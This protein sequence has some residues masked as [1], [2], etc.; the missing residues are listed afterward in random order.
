MELEAA[1]NDPLG[2]VKPDQESFDF[3][4]EVGW[5]RKKR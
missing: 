2:V 5:R 4:I 1:Y 3:V